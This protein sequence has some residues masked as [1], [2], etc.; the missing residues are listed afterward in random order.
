MM[1]E[2]TEPVCDWR[3]LTHSRIGY[4][5][6]VGDGRTLPEIAAQFQVTVNSARSAIEGLKDITG[7][8]DVREMGRWWRDHRGEWLQWCAGEA[9]IHPEPHVS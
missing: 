4:L 3:K 8:R 5:R 7:C 6:E 9:G 1:V 2:P